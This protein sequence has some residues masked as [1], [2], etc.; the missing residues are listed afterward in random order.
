[1]AFRCALFFPDPKDDN[2]KPVSILRGHPV[3]VSLLQGDLLL[4]AG[5]A[6]LRLQQ[7]LDRPRV[8][9]RRGPGQIQQ[10]LHIHRKWK[11]KV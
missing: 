10:V 3:A 4:C 5:R 2:A 9:Q 6:S 7:L 8:R 11:N 1:M